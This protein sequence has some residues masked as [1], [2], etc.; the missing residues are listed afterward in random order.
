MK[1][2]L[3]NSASIP[4]GGG[5]NLITSYKVTNSFV[6]SFGFCNYADSAGAGFLTWRVRI[7]GADAPP[8]NAQKD[9]IGSVSNPYIFDEIKIKNG[10]TITCEINNTGAAAYNAGAIIS[11]E[12]F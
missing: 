4:T 2:T 12:V 3:Q 11:L 8:L 10:D 5:Y 6:A 7:N 1:I 9:A